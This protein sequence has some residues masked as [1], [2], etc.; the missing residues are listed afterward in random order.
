MRPSRFVLLGVVLALAFWVGHPRA[1]APQVTVFHGIGDLPTGTAGDGSAVRDATR[2][3]GTLYAVGSTA[4]G[5]QTP[6]TSV[7]PNLPAGCFVI[8]PP[9]YNLDTPV[10]WTWAGSGNG[11]LTALPPGPNFPVGALPGTPGDQITAYAI[12]PGADYIATQAHNNANANATGSNWYR[13]ATSLLPSTTANLLFSGVTTP[14][15]FPAFTALSIS[16]A[17]SVM[18]GQGSNGAGNTPPTHIRSVVR[19]EQGLGANLVSVAP[20]GKA[21]GYPIPRG[22]SSNGQVMV[23]YAADGFATIGQTVINGAT[24]YRTNTAAFRYVHNPGTLTGT[25][26]A[27]PALP[28]GTWNMP[29]A[30]SASGDTTL[31]IGDSELYPSGEV[32]LTNAANVVTTTLGS[33]NT[34][35]SPRALG[36]MTA[37]GNVIAVTFA[38]GTSFGLGQVSGI[39]LPSANKYAYIH[40]SHGWFN[41]S[42]VLAAEGI[43]LVAMGWDPTNLAITGIRTVDGVD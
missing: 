33:P 29:V 13:A 17:G 5:N 25:T 14:L 4:A 41:I 24:V 8:T 26:T 15:S 27:I 37:D 10:L 19:S 9:L 23:G 16:D 39:G 7:N 12:T 42:N 38:S 22:T 36:G 18:Y 2:V 40:N 20:T 43:N 28:G 11:T 3:N 31:V 34:G 30:I 6:C 21:W 35:M 32:Y 1:Q